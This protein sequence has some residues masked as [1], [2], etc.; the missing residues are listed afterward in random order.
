ML[1]NH[2]LKSIQLKNFRTFYN[3]TPEI[4]FHDDKPINLIVA[5][6]G[7]GKTTLLNAFTWAMYDSI[8]SDV[9]NPKN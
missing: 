4:I 5:E 6:N 2:D 9:E 8:T 3:E 1:I 7:D